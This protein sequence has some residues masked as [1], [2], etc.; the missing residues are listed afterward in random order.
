MR[1]YGGYSSGGRSRSMHVQFAILSHPLQ[2]TV[3]FGKADDMVGDQ[4]VYWLLFSVVPE[5][6]P[7]LVK[8]CHVCWLF[9]SDMT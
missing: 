8:T 4:S 5:T 2:R 9:D 7:N 6:T 1:A 3:R